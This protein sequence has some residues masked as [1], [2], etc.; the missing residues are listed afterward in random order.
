MLMTSGSTRVKRCQKDLMTMLDKERRMKSSRSILAATVA[1]IGLVLAPGFGSQVAVSASLGPIRDSGFAAK[2][3]CHPS[4]MGSAGATI[5][6]VASSNAQKPSYT[7]DL[8]GDGTFGDATGA[9]AITSYLQP[10][11]YAVSVEVVDLPTKAET[12]AAVKVEI[13]KGVS[14]GLPFVSDSFDTQLAGT[15]LKVDSA[16]F[17]FPQGA[18]IV[19]P[20][21]V[22]P[23]SFP[24]ALE[25]L[26]GGSH[27][28]ACMP[29]GTTAAEVSVTAGIDGAPAPPPG[30]W[31]RLVAYASNGKVIDVSPDVMIAEEGQR[32]N[33]DTPI[34]VS[35]NQNQISCV[36][37][38]V[39]RGTGSHDT[40]PRAA[41]IDD[42][43]SYILVP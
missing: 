19:R 16:G 26:N 1:I 35:D 3:T 12:Q 18:K 17:T 33:I 41:I 31:A 2:I 32:S 14:Q 24:N 36:G 29:A 38:F 40:G 20:M 21:N 22:A 13:S 25:A 6:F 11:T 42:L 34:S 15:E 43:G 10:A 23:D 9:A 27:L 4:C 8:N 5:R 37:V 30:T 28:E 39:G 7:W